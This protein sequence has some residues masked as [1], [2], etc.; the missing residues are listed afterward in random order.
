MCKHYAEITQN[1]IYT[2]QNND[3]IEDTLHV[4]EVAYATTE[5]VPPELAKY[6]IFAELPVE[7]KWHLPR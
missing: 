6:L 2:K 5:I 4:W 7:K 1:V 3:Y